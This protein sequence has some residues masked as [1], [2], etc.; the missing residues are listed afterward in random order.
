MMAHPRR[1]NLSSTALINKNKSLD[2]PY[3]LK[4]LWYISSSSSS[5][6]LLSLSLS[7][8]H[9]RFLSLSYFL[10]TPISLTHIFTS[11]LPLPQIIPHPCRLH[12]KFDRLVPLSPFSRSLS[13]LSLTLS[14]SVFRGES[15]KKKYP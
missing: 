9:T 4:G 14:P 2:R 1:L 11:P 3:S 8:S 5:L 15:S 6:L 10:S 12:R 7:L 13:L